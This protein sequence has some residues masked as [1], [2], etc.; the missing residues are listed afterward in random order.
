MIMNTFNCVFWFSYALAV[1][2][3][4]I[5]VPNGLGL[6]FGAIQIFLYLI[7]PRRSGL[8]QIASREPLD[9]LILNEDNISVGSDGSV[10]TEL[11]RRSSMIEDKSII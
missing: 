9:E 1:S 4:F 3:P 7:F 11:K 8:Q 5:A 10:G 2:D 6:L